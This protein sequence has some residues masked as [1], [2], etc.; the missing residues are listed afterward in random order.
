MDF[1]VKVHFPDKTCLWKVQSVEEAISKA[2][3]FLQEEICAPREFQYLC[4][5]G[6]WMPFDPLDEDEHN[7][8]LQRDVVEIKVYP[9]MEID[10]TWYE[11]QID[12]SF[13]K[14][15]TDSVSDTYSE[16][17]SSTPS[18]LESLLNA[19]YLND[20]LNRKLIIDKELSLD[21]AIEVLDQIKKAGWDIAIRPFE[22]GER[23][24]FNHYQNFADHSIRKERQS[25]QSKLKSL[26]DSGFL[27]EE[28]NRQLIVDKK[29]S[30]SSA[31]QELLSRQRCGHSEATSIK[32]VEGDQ[33]ENSPAQEEERYQEDSTENHA[34]FVSEHPCD[35]T[36]K[37]KLKLLLKSGFLNEKLNRYLLVEKQMSVHLAIETL[38]LLKKTGNCATS[39]R[40]ATGR[41]SDTQRKHHSSNK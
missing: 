33:V 38:L 26:S 39:L 17:Q 12:E 16:A 5:S 10:D 4:E 7:M 34:E 11:D 23:E 30:V 1:H 9:K 8:L 32:K 25:I 27:N 20:E 13:E 21:S 15:P 2:T 18:K 6:H 19:G 29:M 28:L 14:S 36:T 41:R 24:K 22:S 40:D 35:E 3:H 37:S 31:V